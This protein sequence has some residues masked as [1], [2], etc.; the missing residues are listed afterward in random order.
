MTWRKSPR[1]R[2]AMR[3]IELQLERKRT[4]YGRA[5]LEVLGRNVEIWAYRAVLRRKGQSK[6]YNR[7]VYKI[8]GRTVQDAAVVALLKQERD[9]G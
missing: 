8:N 3:D 6:L 4:R 5:S 1:L 9:N 2:D 7:Y